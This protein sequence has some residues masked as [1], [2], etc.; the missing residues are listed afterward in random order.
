MRLSAVN[1]GM[2]GCGN[3][4]E[5]K[6]GPAFNKV[7]G[8]QLVAV[9]RR[10]GEKAR[11]YAIRHNVPRWYDDAEQLIND[12]EVNAVY[13]ATPPGSHAEYAIRTMKAG[14]P[15]YV[16]K[17]MAATYNECLEMISVSEQT[18]V[19]LFVAYYRRMLPGF[20]KI[21][22][23]LDSGAIGHPRFF[24]IRLFQP[25]CK[26]D[27]QKTLPW[28]VI[29]EISGGGYIYDLGSHQIDLIDYLLGPIEETGSYTTN[30][31]GLYAPEDFVSSGFR[32]STG[33][34]GSGTW[35]FAAP[36][37]LEED[38]IEIFGDTGKIRFSCFG[39]TAT[40]LTREGQ[41]T[42]FA[43]PRPDHVQ[44]PLI[45]TIV[46]ELSGKGKCPAT[47]TSSAKTSLL[48]DRITGKI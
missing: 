15:V 23:L 19:P 37:R 17:P 46:E 16:E 7:R 13:I 42:H 26:E 31:A 27:M 39:F 24:L 34:A 9:M 45:Q 22:E 40:E 41:T 32:C 20:I 36:D 3:V 6:S 8:S 5:V 33:I 10:N 1:W 38:T 2:I 48:L 35:N 47:G 14:K 18:G 11:D 29:P 12:P 44:Q 43:N 25:P 21:K 28:R 4:A 30:L